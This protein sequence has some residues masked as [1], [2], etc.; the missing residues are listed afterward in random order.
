LFFLKYSDFKSIM[1]DYGYSKCI[2]SFA[3]IISVITNIG[4]IEPAIIKNINN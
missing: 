3:G 2:S 1:G 4:T